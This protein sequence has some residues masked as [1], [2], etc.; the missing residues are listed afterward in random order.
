MTFLNTPPS[1]QPTTSSLV[2][3]RNSVGAEQL[4]QRLGHGR[5]VHGEHRRGGG[6]GHDLLGQVRSGE[7]A[8]RVAGQHLVDDLG[9]AQAG[10]ELEALGEAHDRHPRPDVG[11]R[12][13]ASVCAERLRRHAHHHHVGR[14]RAPRRARWSPAAPGAARQS[15]RYRLLRCCSLIS[16]HGVRPSGPTASWVRCAAQRWATVVP[17]EP[18]PR[19]ATLIDDMARTLVRSLLGGPSDGGRPY[20]APCMAAPPIAVV[21]P[22]KDFTRA[23]VRLAEHLDAAARAALARDMAGIV[24][25]AAGPAAR[26]GRVRRRPTSGPGPTS[27]G[28]EVI[29]TPGLGLNGAV[30]AGVDRAGTPRGAPPWSSPTPTCRWPPRWRGSPR[31]RASPSCPT[32]ASTAPT[33]SPC[34][35]PPGFR[36]SYGA[37]SFER[38]RAEGLRLGLPGADRPRRPAGLGRRPPG[39]PRPARPLL[40]SEPDL[41]TPPHRRGRRPA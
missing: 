40:M 21:V 9:H 18:P 25:A 28:A 34:R 19:T 8:G 12:P 31:P 23:K 1:S 27:V 2:Y 17:H 24:L 22:V 41:P 20:T 37:G 36:F 35:P 39:R 33:C 6:T 11:R 13:R 7:H 30:Q 15:G 38:H 3:T 10:A 4:L 29:W 26:V 5:V 16:S 14:C 32:G